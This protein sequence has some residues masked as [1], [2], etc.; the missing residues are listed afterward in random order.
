MTIEVNLMYDFEPPRVHPISLKKSLASIELT[1]DF[2]IP[3]GVWEQY[4]DNEEKLLE[5]AINAVLVP[6]LMKSDKF[7]PTVDPNK[8]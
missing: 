7:K 3:E 6:S 5:W 2:D 4:K 8:N 1:I